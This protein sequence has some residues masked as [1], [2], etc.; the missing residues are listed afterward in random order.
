MK[1]LREF[2]VQRQTKGEVQVLRLI[3]PLDDYTFNQLQVTLNRCRADG[4]RKI[5][6]ECNDLDHMSTTAI[7]SLAEYCRQVRDEKGEVLLASL[8][9]K[10]LNMIEVLGHTAD[11]KVL[12]SEK[13]AVKQLDPEFKEEEEKTKII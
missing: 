2:E 8:S 12:D 4:Q 1:P 10:I 3:G 9:D 5:V 7:E 6:M 11:F 13:D